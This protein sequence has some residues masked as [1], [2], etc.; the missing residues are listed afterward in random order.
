MS[1]IP[2]GLDP[3]AAVELLK[4][5]NAMGLTVAEIAKHFKSMNQD[6]VEAVN[7]ENE[8]LNIETKRGKVLSDNA[9]AAKDAGQ[10]AV[11]MY[12]QEENAV[13][14]LKI[15]AEMTRDQNGNLSD[16]GK[17]LMEQARVSREE[18]QSRR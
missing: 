4:T 12:M 10:G 11:N 15:R 3:A 14:Q 16:A 1:D 5:L 7:L 2:E 17:L 9:Q 18:Q 13:R 6:A 8:R